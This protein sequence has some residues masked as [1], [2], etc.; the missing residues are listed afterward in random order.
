MKI[1]YFLLICASSL[2]SALAAKLPSPAASPAVP[3]AFEKGVMKNEPVLF[4]QREGE[5]VAKARL[6]FTPLAKPVITHPD[7]LMHYY[8]GKDYLWK[9][10]SNEIELTVSSL[11]PFKTLAQMFP[12]EGSPNGR[13]GM[14][15]LKGKG[16]MHLCANNHFFHDLQVQVTYRHDGAFPLPDAPANRLP[17]S[18]GKLQAKQ[19]IKLVALGDSI[20]QGYS[21]SGFKQSW[22][23]PYQPAYP[24]LV[25][26]NLEEHFGSRVDLVNLG[27]ATKKADWGLTRVD[28]VTSEKPDLVILAFG[29]NHVEDVPAFEGIMKEMCGRI[30]A[31]CPEADIILVAP[32]LPN[33]GLRSWDCFMERLKAFRRL[34][35]PNIALA[36]VTTP[37]AELLKHKEYWE[38]SG[39]NVNHPN[40]FGHRLYAQVI[41]RLYFQ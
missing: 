13:K 8:E 6:L 17:R 9:P 32:M 5:A 36:D 40:D 38:V 10:G 26:R 11:I 22:A 7:Q 37:W 3:P 20:T 35:G 19:P 31:A 2:T 1:A 39:N 21:A 24:G 29:M 27:V 30:Q 41:C 33:P 14:P 15:H 12:P 25:A 28:A 34:E 16:G 4:I 23:P 18:L